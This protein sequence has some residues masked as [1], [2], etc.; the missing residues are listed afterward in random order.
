MAFALFY[1]LYMTTTY[2]PSELNPQTGSVFSQMKAVL[3]EPVMIAGVAAFWL[4]ALPF[5]A[6]SLACVRVWETFVAMK[7]SQAAQPNPLILRR[8]RR[9][10]SASAFSTGDAVHSGQL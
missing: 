6:M 3:M 9:A 8:G 5:V 1:G 10:K 7:S 4:L 2:F